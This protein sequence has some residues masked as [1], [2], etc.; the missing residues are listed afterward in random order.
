MLVLK[1]ENI[2]LGNQNG[3]Y[4]V[5]LQNSLLELLFYECIIFFHSFASFVVFFLST[6]SIIPNCLKTKILYAFTVTLKA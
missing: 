2:I 3:S 6:F 1:A 4:T 5:S